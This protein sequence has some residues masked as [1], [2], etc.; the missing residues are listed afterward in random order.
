VRLRLRG[1]CGS[2]LSFCAPVEREWF[3]LPDRSTQ[4]MSL[5]IAQRHAWSL[6]RTLMVC[7]TLFQ[8]GDEYS[9]MPSADYDGDTNKIVREY[10]P[11]CF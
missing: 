4:I 8:A 7:I 11:F 1:D 3:L 2:A 5:F 9:V 10:D 6:A